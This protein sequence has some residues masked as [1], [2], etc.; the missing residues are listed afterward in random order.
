MFPRSEWDKRKS[1]DISIILVK[2]KDAYGARVYS[3]QHL[4]PNPPIIE[5]SVDGIGSSLQQLL[6]EGSVLRN[7]WLFIHFM[8]T[9]FGGDVKFRD[10][11]IKATEFADQIGGKLQPLL[12]CHTNELTKLEMI[13]CRAGVA[14]DALKAIAKAFGARRAFGP[15]ANDLIGHLLAKGAG[16]RE[17]LLES[18]VGVN[19]AQFDQTLRGFY[20]LLLNE[21]QG[22]W[23]NEPIGLPHIHPQNWSIN[24]LEDLKK[25]YFKAQGLAYRTLMK[26]PAG[27]SGHITEREL[28]L[29]RKS[30]REKQGTIITVDV[31]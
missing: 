15:S 8:P 28:E 4:T 12:N 11:W 18:D 26:E 27:V 29:I 3:I 10:R 20:D 25:E 2:G 1:I 6:V 7:I 30:H 22:L 31:Q 24:S 21:Q 5:D 9:Q 23:R 16:S 19:A 17:I 14:K 13:G